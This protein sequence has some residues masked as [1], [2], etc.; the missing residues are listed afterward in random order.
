M[1]VRASGERRALHL[2]NFGGQLG[3]A[4]SGVTHGHNAAADAFGIAA[5]NVATAAGGPFIGGATNP[6]ELFS[7]DGYRRVFFDADGTPLTP[8]Q[9]LFGNGG[10][11]RR[12]PDL[13][14]ADGVQTT[15]PGFQPFFGTSAAA[16]HAAAIAALLKSARPRLAPNRIR[17]ALQQTALDI[18]AVGRDCDS[19][20]GIVDAF[21]ALQ[22]IGAPPAPFLDLGTVTS[23]A[24]GGDGDA[25]IEPGESASMLAQLVNVGGATALNVTGT[26]ATSTT[27]VTLGVSQSN[28]PNIGSNGQ[29]AVNQHALH[30]QPGAHCNVRVAPEFSLTASYSNGRTAHRCSRSRSRRDSRARRSPTCA[31]AGPAVAI[32][33]GVP[34]GTSRPARRQWRARR[35]REPDVLD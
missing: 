25:F 5:V 17:R 7:S 19:G 35:H 34:A 23:T 12:K 30:V 8:G 16:P 24:V 22:D 33:D 14:A 2:N 11:L 6:V 29:A 13:A 28:Y 9:F 15:V 27:G 4:T 32:P 21:G 26:L 3:I 18:E 1:I 20:F 10:Q 31:Y